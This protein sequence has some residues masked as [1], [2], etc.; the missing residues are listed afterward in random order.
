MD[1]DKNKMQANGQEK[2]CSVEETIKTQKSHPK[3]TVYWYSGAIPFIQV[4]KEKK[5]TRIV[6]RGEE[7]AF[8]YHY[9]QCL[10]VPP[11]QV[12]CLS[13]GFTG[14]ARPAVVFNIINHLRGTACIDLSTCTKVRGERQRQVSTRMDTVD[15]IGTWDLSTFC[16]CGDSGFRGFLLIPH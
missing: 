8:H 6:R 4:T 13:I 7:S 15:P 16:W 3:T 11:W 9:T 2:G 1:D 10:R 14:Q 12:K 5:K